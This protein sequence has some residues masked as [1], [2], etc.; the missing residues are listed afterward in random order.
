MTRFL[1]PAALFALLSTSCVGPLEPEVGE[2]T[3]RSCDNEDSNP[4]VDVSFETDLKP[5]FQAGCGCHNPLSTMSG[6]SIGSTGF[7]VGDYA[8]LMRGGQNSGEKI[9]I[10]GDPCGS[11]LYQKMTNAPPNG[12]RMPINGPYWSRAD[13]QLLSDWIAEGARAN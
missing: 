13:M 8:A 9:V 1:L 12:S 3:A 5:K 4:D 2:L 6:G 7:S 10:E 11:Y